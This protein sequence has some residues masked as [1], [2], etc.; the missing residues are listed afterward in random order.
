MRTLE[1]RG[2]LCDPVD[3][4]DP[5]PCRDDPITSCRQKPHAMAWGYLLG[6]LGRVD[7]RREL[8]LTVWLTQFGKWRRVRQAGRG[9]LLNAPD[10]QTRVSAYMLT[11]CF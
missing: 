9:F 10:K 1:R 6:K 2:L 11:T 4:P 8:V 5:D 3:A 7:E